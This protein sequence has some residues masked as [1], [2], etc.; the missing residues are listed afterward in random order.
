MK[1]E[2][3]TTCIRSYFAAYC[4]KTHLFAFEKIPTFSK[5]LATLSPVWDIDSFNFCI[6]T[7]DF[8][9]VCQ[10]KVAILL[11]CDIA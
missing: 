3:I 5:K 7:I 9:A 4:G 8:A 2:S 1:N 11:F 10:H 6:K